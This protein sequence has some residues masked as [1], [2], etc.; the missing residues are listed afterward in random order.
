MASSGAGAWE[1]DPV[2][3]PDTEDVMLLNVNPIPGNH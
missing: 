2:T 3:G 1:V